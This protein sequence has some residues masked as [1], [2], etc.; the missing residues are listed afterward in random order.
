MKSDA[1]GVARP[2]GCRPRPAARA[3]H[4]DGA[5]READR[6]RPGRPAEALLQARGRGIQPPGV[7]LER[8]CRRARPWRRC[9]TA[10]RAARRSRRSRR[11]A[12][13]SWSRCRPARARAGAASLARS[14]R[15]SPRGEHLPPRHLDRVHLGERALGDLGEQVA[16]P[17]EDRHEHAVARA[18]ERD[19][20]RLDARARRC[21]RRAAS[22]RCGCPRPR[23]RAPASRSCRGHGRVV[24]ADERRR[25]RA[26]HP[27]VRVDGPGP[28]SRRAGGL[29]GPGSSARSRGLHASRERTAAW[30][31][32]TAADAA[33]PRGA[34]AHGAARRRARR[35]SAMS[36]PRATTR[37][38]PTG[39]GRAVGP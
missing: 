20:R 35:T 30:S 37:Q 1:D 7:H 39:A 36:V 12:G 22:P 31:G 26:Q 27:R 21:R 24:L 4:L 15:R 5:V 14:P 16:E 29:I 3:H 11:A 19:D 9:R 6:R 8:R 23:G 18:D 2:R 17:P 28:I 13:P 33:L 38:T 32:E 34:E 10:R 25:H